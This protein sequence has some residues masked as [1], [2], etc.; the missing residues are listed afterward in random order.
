MLR[1]IRTVL[2]WLVSLY[3]AWL[4]LNQGVVKFDQE[5]FWTAAFERWG[6]PEWLRILVG[7]IETLG[8][9]LLLVPRVATYAALGVAAVMIGAI[10]TRAGDGRWVDVAWNTLYLSAL[11]WIAYERRPKAEGVLT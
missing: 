1:R 9:I 8:G 5:G 6:Y 4:F 2:I 3:L 7:G 10:V 11:L